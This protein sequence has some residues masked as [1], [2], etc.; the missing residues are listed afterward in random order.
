MSFR[1]SF[2]N[3]VQVGIVEV[4][5]QEGGGPY[6]LDEFG[7]EVGAICGGNSCCRN[8]CHAVAMHP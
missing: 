8:V 7:I 2:I 3:G 5:H 1:G 6:L 4:V